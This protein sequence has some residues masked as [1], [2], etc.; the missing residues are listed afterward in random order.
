METTIVLEHYTALRRTYSAFLRA[1]SLP[2]TESLVHGLITF[3][4]SPERRLLEGFNQPKTLDIEPNDCDSTNQSRATYSRLIVS[5]F[6]YADF[7][8]LTDS[9]RIDKLEK[10]AFEIFCDYL[11]ISV[12]NTFEHVEEYSNSLNNYIQLFEQLK[13]TEGD[14]ASELRQKIVENF[15]WLNLLSTDSCLYNFAKVFN[16]LCEM[17]LR[18]R[19]IPLDFYFVE[20]KNLTESS[21]L[22]IGFYSTYL[23]NHGHGLPFMHGILARIAEQKSAKVHLL[24][25]LSPSDTQKDRCSAILAKLNRSGVTSHIF[26]NEISIS[27][28]RS[29][30]LDLLFFLDAYNGVNPVLNTTASLP[31]FRLA[32]VQGTAFFSPT[33]TG[34]KN[35]DFYVTNKALECGEDIQG[36]FTEKLYFVSTLPFCLDPMSYFPSGQIMENGR[37]NHVHLKPSNLESKKKK[38]LICI[39]SSVGNKLRGEF[40]DFLCKL[41]L[42]NSDSS[43]IVMPNPKWPSECIDA[44]FEHGSISAEVKFFRRFTELGICR[45]RI[46]IDSRSTR[47]ALYEIL[48]QSTLFVDYFPFTGT[49]SII[50]PLYC[51]CPAITLRGRTHSRTRIGAHI[52]DS[53]GLSALVADD[54]TQLHSIATRLLSD[55]VLRESTVRQISQ[56][57]WKDS[58]LADLE[59][60]VDEIYGVFITALSDLGSRKYSP[61]RFGI[62]LA[63][64]QQ[65]EWMKHEQRP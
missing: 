19:E 31:F 23:E 11:M 24:G 22:K 28:I 25:C 51:G 4:E 55:S 60:Y 43:I 10:W 65:S 29:L 5:K 58:K 6:L 37:L 30:D 54:Y 61:R 17:E 20:D 16:D 9:V 14:Q 45:N 36:R 7:G 62:E 2:L 41:L 26:E 32:R 3:I 52:L 18:L 42:E 40:V 33:T 48:C 21:P 46:I 63:K 64:F 57:N 35:M 1:F 12:P 15:K 49:N 53:L 47:E 38:K 56:I 8:A 27:Y 50:D 13:V 34:I 44:P 59:T 39:G